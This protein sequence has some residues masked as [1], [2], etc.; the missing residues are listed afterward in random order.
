MKAGRKKPGKKRIAR[1]FSTAPVGFRDKPLDWYY[2][3]EYRQSP[4]TNKI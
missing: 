3:L 1:Y 4:E 2:C